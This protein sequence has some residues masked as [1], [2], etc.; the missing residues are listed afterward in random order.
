MTPCTHHICASGLRNVDRCI[1]RLALFE[2]VHKIVPASVAISEAIQLANT[3][4]EEDAYQYIN[5]VLGAVV[6]A[7]DLE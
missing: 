3:F 5:G 4:A 2:I 6:R 1:F 7:H